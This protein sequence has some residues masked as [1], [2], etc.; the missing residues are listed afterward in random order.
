[1]SVKE[2]FVYTDYDGCA[3]ITA[4]KLYRCEIIHGTLGRISAIRLQNCG[5]TILVSEKLLLT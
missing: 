3:Y 1:M 4:G 5:K 2:V